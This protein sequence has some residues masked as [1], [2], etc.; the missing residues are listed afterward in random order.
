MKTSQNGINLLKQFE[1]CRLTAYK[2]LPSETYYTIGYGHYGADVR[3]GMRITQD[4]AE[5]LL[6]KDLEK[7][8]Y[9]VNC[10][11]AIYHWSQN[12]FDA[13]VSF[14]YNLGSIHQ[15]TN[16]GKRDRKTIA[17]K[18]LLY[19]NSGGVKIPGLVTRRKKEQELFLKYSTPSVDP[20]I[21]AKPTLRKGMK[22]SKQVRILQE[23]LNLAMEK[24][25]ISFGDKLVIDGSYGSLTKQAV[26]DLQTKYY[27][28][29]YFDKIDGIY[30]KHT[31]ACLKE[32]L[33]NGI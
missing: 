2:C 33:T 24:A 5:E 7:Y 32:V 6:K 12:E 15:L 9:Q 26:I 25:Y 18:M 14:A 8:E 23:N 11:N 3:I 20:V 1:G 19:V 29:L 17:E 13:L 4:Q 27:G 31:E 21:I 30:G 16:Y 22:N 10:Y 28:I